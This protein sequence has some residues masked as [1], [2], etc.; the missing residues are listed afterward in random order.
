MVG[1]EENEGEDTEGLVREILNEMR[2]LRESIE[3]HA[4]QKRVSTKSESSAN[5]N[6]PSR[7]YNRQI[8]MRFVNRQHRELVWRNKENIS[9]SKKYIGAFFAPDYPKEIAQEQSLLRKAARR[10]R[11]NEI[12]PEIRNNRLYLV[13][14]Q[15]SYS[16]KEL[17]EFLKE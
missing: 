8:I 2:V 6:G 3:F 13:N 1:I 10:A 5:G 14:S 12:K 7:L 4:V 11:D 15:T 9:K 16:L 17:P